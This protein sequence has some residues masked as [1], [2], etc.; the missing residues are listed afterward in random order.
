MSFQEKNQI[1]IFLHHPHDLHKR[2]ITTN[3]DVESI[4]K[5]MPATVRLMNSA[6]ID[7]QNPRAK[8]SRYPINAP[9]Y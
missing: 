3:R 7:P 8:Q 5:L 9:R 1:K 4:K 6:R 2:R